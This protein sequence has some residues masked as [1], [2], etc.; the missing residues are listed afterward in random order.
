MHEMFD[1]TAVGEVT[2][3]WEKGLLK[4]ESC[5]CGVPFRACPFWSEVIRD[6][7]GHVTE[8]DAR[9]FDLAFRSVR[10]R[11]TELAG[12]TGRFGRGNAVFREVV[13]ALYESAARIG[14]GRP[15][16]DSSKV[17]TFAAAVRK[18]DLGSF[19]GLHIFRDACGNV[20]SLRT[21]KRRP[22]ARTQVDAEIHPSRS[23]LHAI[24]RWSIL[25]WEARQL[26]KELRESCA[27][28]SYERFCSDPDRHLAGLQDSFDLAPR[29][30]DVNEAW[31]SVSGNPMR[32][33]PGG[34][35]IQLDER[36]KS[37]MTVAARLFTRAMTE[38]QQRMLESAAD[39]WLRGRSAP[40]AALPTAAAA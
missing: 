17:P 27:T 38:V 15:I 26:A 28:I 30:G 8:S 5:S 14:G 12:L 40:A 24:G 37:Q 25:N 22:H 18:L 33:D 10:G 35:R 39:K 29:R 31:H 4:N 32:F 11:L 34:T 21:A 9:R 3:I 1:V 13:A 2:Y 23:V 6:A 19:G 16:I 20:Q 7:F 36:W